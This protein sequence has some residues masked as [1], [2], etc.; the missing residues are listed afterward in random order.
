MASIQIVSGLVLMA[1]ASSM[2]TAP[3]QT[4]LAIRDH[5]GADVRQLCTGVT[6]GGGALLGCL[7]QHWGQVSP[8]CKDTLA[9]AKA[10]RAAQ[11]S[12]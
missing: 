3:D 1:S 6:P 9:E 5:C 11:S 7:K 12:N 2:S 4:A 10:R 8:I